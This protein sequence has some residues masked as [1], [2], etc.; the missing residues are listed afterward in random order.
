MQYTLGAMLTF[1]LS[2][3]I[4][5]FLYPIGLI[6]ML[7]LLA[8]WL[9]K[10]PGWQRAAIVAALALVWVGGNTWVADSLTRA[11]EWQYLPPGELPR[12]EVI[13]LLGGGTH[14]AQ[15]PRSTVEVSG[16]GDRVIYAAH[17]YHQGVAPQILSSGGIVPLVGPNATSAEDMAQLLAMMGVP[18]EAIWL[19]TISRNTAENA[20]HAWAFL[21]ERGIQRIVLVTSAQHMPRAVCLFEAQGFEVIPA[22]TDYTIT[23]ASWEQ[24]WQPD[25]AAQLINFFPTA[26][27]LSSTTS[28]LKEFFGMLFY[29]WQGGV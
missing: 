18:P 24:L 6:W 17:L 4:P 21:S 27:N 14:S 1:F 19:E 23:Q 8:L 7:L 3:F 20:Q 25:L 12:A 16:A 9:W 28:S 2:K 10:R 15:Y 22:P 26:S 5:L 29:R 11:L 13:V